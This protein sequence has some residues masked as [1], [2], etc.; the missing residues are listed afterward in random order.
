MCYWLLNILKLL[1]KHIM[2]DT[3]FQ[4]KIHYKH[5]I[6]LFLMHSDIVDHYDYCQPAINK[7]YLT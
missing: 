5:E 6:I 7:S 1:L 2:Y 3:S 4:H